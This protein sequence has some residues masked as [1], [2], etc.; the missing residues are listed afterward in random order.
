MHDIAMQLRRHFSSV[1]RG[2]M[3]N[4]IRS[5]VVKHYG[6]QLVLDSQAAPSA[7]GQEGTSRRGID[8][9]GPSQG[10]DAAAVSAATVALQAELQQTRLDK[11]KAQARTARSGSAG[12]EAAE[13][14]TKE[15]LAALRDGTSCQ[16]H[17]GKAS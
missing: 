4:V 11:I 5:A 8:L 15:E 14:F 12:A 6:R 3:D 16:Q 10:D 7:A 9:L 2:K 1:T 13:V 17:M